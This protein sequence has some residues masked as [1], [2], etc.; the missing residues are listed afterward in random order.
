MAMREGEK[1]IWDLTAVR[2]KIRRTK[3]VFKGS[4]GEHYEFRGDVDK[5]LWDNNLDGFYR[6]QVIR[7][8]GTG[9]IVVQGAA[10]SINQLLCD[11]GYFVVKEHRS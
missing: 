1:L 6:P 4:R 8:K 2:I 3:I 10:E 11:L 5:I 9:K 7:E